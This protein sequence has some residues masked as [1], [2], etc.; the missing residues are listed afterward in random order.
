MRTNKFLLAAFTLFLSITVSS[1]TDSLGLQQNTVDKLLASQNKL[2]IG[3]YAQI[4]Y[5]QG[6]DKSTRYNGVLDVHR[7]V[8]LFGYRFNSK[9]QFVTELEYEHVNEIFVEQ[10]FLQHK[11]NSFINLKAGLLLIPMGLVNEYHEPTAFNGVERPLIDNYI[12]PTTWREVGAGFNGIFPSAGV[13]YQLFVVN[14]FSSYNGSAKLNGKKG[15]RDGRQKGAESF[16]SSP[17]LTGRID[18]FAIKNLQLGASVY[19]GNTESTLYNGIAKNDVVGNNKADSSVVGISM[20]GL[21]ARYRIGKLQL[22]GQYYYTAISNSNQYN[23]FTKKAAGNNDLGSSMTGYYGEVAYS[24]SLGKKSEQELVPFVRIESYNTHNSVGSSTVRNK[25]YN[26]Q[27]ITSGLGWKLNKYA[28]LKA[29]VQWIKPESASSYST[30]IN[31]GI[32]VMF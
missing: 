28:V 25:N 18:Y 10:A 15:F 19:L 1:Q 3:G 5:N 26:N 2:T 31:A 27:L 24:I 22:K 32:G 9:T 20:L 7:V 17:N 4:D 29:D 30:A 13:K 12:S 8:V 11:L 6:L 21:D 23:V 14:G 16:V